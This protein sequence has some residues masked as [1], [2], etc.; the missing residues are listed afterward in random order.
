MNIRDIACASAMSEEELAGPDFLPCRELSKDEIEQQIDFWASAAERA[1]KEAGFD[2]CESNHAT[3]HQG[4]TFLSRIWNK[5]TDEYGPQ[6]F[7]NR[8]RFLRRCVEEAKKRTGPNFAVHV[9]M[10]ASEYN[11]PEATTLEEEV[12]SRRDLL[13]MP[14]VKVL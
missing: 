7:E 5:R 3:C 1:Y 13:S 6:S 10:N 8:T 4:N 12:V 14:S 9:L 11:N 2:A